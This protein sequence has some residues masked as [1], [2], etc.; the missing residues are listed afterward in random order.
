MLQIE[1]DALMHATYVHDRWCVNSIAVWMLGC[2]YLC[3]IHNDKKLGQLLVTI[4]RRREQK[5]GHLLV[6]I[7]CVGYF[8][9]I[10]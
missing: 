1:F 7:F 3:L 2:T 10:Y 9:T 4:Y 8:H 5:T 6:R